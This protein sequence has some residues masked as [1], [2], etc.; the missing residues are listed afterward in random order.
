MVHRSPRTTISTYLVRGLPGSQV[1]REFQSAIDLW[2]PISMRTYNCQRSVSRMVRLIYG[3][4]L[5]NR[6]LQ[7]V[8]LVMLRCIRIFPDVLPWNDVLNDVEYWGHD[9]VR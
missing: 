8:L 6:K 4:I 1:C 5:L 7:Y 3:N 9:Q 2:E